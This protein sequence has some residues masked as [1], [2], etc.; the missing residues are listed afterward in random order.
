MVCS[1]HTTRKIDVNVSALDFLR[2]NR[3]VPRYT[4]YPPATEFK[5]ISDLSYEKKLLNFVKEDL[6]IYIHI[7]FCNSMCLYC[8]C[9]VILNRKKENQEE[10][11]QFLLLEINKVAITLPN[12]KN[13]KHLHFGGGTPS[14]LENE[15]MEL[16]FSSLKNHFKLDQNVEISIEI[17][18]RYCSL[19]KLEFY[20]SLGINRV[21]FGVQDTDP[22]V[23]KAVR[24]NQSAELS[25]KTFLDA[26][27]VGFSGI[28]IDLIYGLPL[29]TKYTFASTI[30]HILQM[31][32]DRIALFSYAQVPWLKPHQKAIK[33]NEL[34]STIEKFEIYVLAR[35]AF[36]EAG[37]TPI[38]MDHFALKEDELAQAYLEKKLHR[39]FQ[40]YTTLKSEN[41][42]GLGVSS[43]GLVEGLYIQNVKSLDIYYQMLK[44]NKLPV[45]VGKELSY[46]DQV[47]Y[48]VNKSLMCHFQVDKKEFNQKFSLDF[49]NYFEKERKA[50]LPYLQEGLVNE[51]LDKI[52][53]TSTGELFI[54][55]IASCFDRY[56]QEGQQKK[57]SQSI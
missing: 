49:D 15:E 32:P 46:D 9:S 42:I 37:Y 14:L 21:S 56:Y 18:P 22:E 50:L 43:I 19:S 28:N 31:R 1:N 5:P 38:G 35:K 57:F 44:E 6:S 52:V 54:R 40:G 30:E 2:L 39:N 13:I 26:K 34:P 7:P 45:A 17:D 33:E 29:Q 53:A 36:I 48:F 47:R 55:L 25:L 51:D 41:L 4:S 8:A 20:K 3:P 12:K 24:R 27:Q 10:Y 23:Q 11:V 16:I